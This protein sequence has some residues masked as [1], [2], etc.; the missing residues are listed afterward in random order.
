MGS[1]VESRSYRAHSSALVNVYERAA[2]SIM[3]HWSRLS[4]T[5][6]RWEDYSKTRRQ[7][8]LQS[9]SER[10]SEAS[11]KTSLSRSRKSETK[12]VSEGLTSEVSC[13]LILTMRINRTRGSE[14]IPHLAQLVE[15]LTVVG[16]NN[17]SADI[18]VSPVQV[19][20]WGP[21][22]PFTRNRLEYNM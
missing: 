16:K 17:V 5:H 15:H 8:G 6:R 3:H 7:S 2:R 11:V 14:G 10:R 1:R 9:K 22:V 13:G 12:S 18:R 21:S 20:E 4:R 19:R